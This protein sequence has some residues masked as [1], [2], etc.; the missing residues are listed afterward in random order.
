MQFQRPACLPVWLAGISVCLV[1]VSGLAAIYRSTP[2]SYTEATMRA[3]IVPMAESSGA[4]GALA[5]PIAA[6]PNAIDR[7]TRWTC[8]ECGV[9]ASMHPIERS[10]HVQITVRFRDGSTTSFNE[11]HSRVWQTGERVMVIAGLNASNP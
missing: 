9:V 5:D 11:T 1:A 8:A 2:G 4:D 6:A 10:G 7:R 3:Q